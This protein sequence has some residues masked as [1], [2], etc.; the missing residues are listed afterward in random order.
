[1]IEIDDAGGGCFIGPEVLVIHKLENGAVRYLYIPPQVQERIQYA[2]KILSEAFREMAVSEEEPIR[3]CRGEIFDQF[4]ASLEERGYQVVREKVSAE[5]DCLAE[6]RFLEILQSY[7]FPANLTLKDRNYQQFYQLVGCWYYSQGENRQRGIRK[8]RLR[9]PALP[10][11][12]GQRFPN[13][14]KLILEEQAVG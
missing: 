14:A 5:T 1:M 9:P 13:L 2:A 7:G 3:L 10:R 6:Q 8:T 11:K 12:M 4:Q